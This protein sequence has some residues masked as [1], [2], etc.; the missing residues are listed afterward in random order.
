MFVTKNKSDLQRDGF[1]DRE[2][3]VHTHFCDE[4]D[5]DDQE[6]IQI[7]IPKEWYFPRSQCPESVHE[8]YRRVGTC[9]YFGYFP[10]DRI[11]CDFL[12]KNYDDRS[13][14]ISS[15]IMKKLEKLLEG[16]GM[17]KRKR[18]CNGSKY[19][20]FNPFLE[21]DRMI[22]EFLVKI[23]GRHLTKE[24]LWVESKRTQLANEIVNFLTNTPA[25]G[26]HRF[27]MFD[28]LTQKLRPFMT[29][30]LT[31]FSF[32]IAQSCNSTFQFITY[33]WFKGIA[34]SE[35]IQAVA[36]ELAKLYQIMPQSAAAN[37]FVFA[38]TIDN[39]FALFL[40]YAAM[41]IDSTKLV[42]LLLE[43]YFS[44]FAPQC[45]FIF[46]YATM[47][48][49]CCVVLPLVLD[50]IWLYGHETLDIVETSILDLAKRGKN[51]EESSFCID[52]IFR[53]ASIQPLAERRV[54]DVLCK[55]LEHDKSLYRDDIDLWQKLV[56]FGFK[57][58]DFALRHAVRTTNCLFLE[59]ASSQPDIEPMKVVEE[60]L[61]RDNLKLFFELHDKY[62]TR[63]V[64][65]ERL[66]E[67]CV[68]LKWGSVIESGKAFQ[69]FIN[70]KR[71]SDWKIDIM[72]SHLKKGRANIFIDLLNILS[73]EKLN[74]ITSN[75]KFALNCVE[76]LDS[77]TWRERNALSE[78]F[79]KYSSFEDTT[80]IQQLINLREYTLATQIL[81]KKSW[82]D[83][84]LRSELRIPLLLLRL[85][86]L[87]T[88]DY[89]T[90]DVVKFAGELVKSGLCFTK[91]DLH[92]IWKKSSDLYFVIFE[93]CKNEQ[94]VNVLKD[95][96]YGSR[97]TNAFF[98]K[99]RVLSTALLTLHRLCERNF[100]FP[101][102]SIITFAQYVVKDGNITVLSEVLSIFTGDRLKHVNR[103]KS[104]LKRL[105]S[106]FSSHEEILICFRDHG[107][108]V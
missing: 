16:D 102:T 47:Y 18:N 20:P 14:I 91:D 73:P 37:I 69:Y 24:N 39:Q 76:N 81:R 3:N 71:F 7:P 85:E 29:F 106:S 11:T 101:K 34:Y 41:D 51:K 65:D 19:L 21:E 99:R 63:F 104:F 12:F 33:N 61:K 55:L 46:N 84:S 88:N 62:P 96:F 59:F 60:V 8:L 103:S 25:K 49:S 89:S 53:I 67:F 57:V 72:I 50:F 108:N 83:D 75:P 10:Y 17:P 68:E 93:K 82:T 94:Q 28:L 32:E 97:C 36:N 31:D 43:N 56:A 90:S 5:L 40:L 77:I 70:D 78:L 105:S 9:N 64:I 98:R 58:T 48:S 45:N 4:L 100:A 92:Q 86:N 1:Y 35:P 66:L 95:T 27:F 54:T 74:A 80:L 30:L 44:V 13:L 23:G 79:D 107:I 22:I 26:E 87:K 15:K 38:S 52:A 2:V 6:L 42:K